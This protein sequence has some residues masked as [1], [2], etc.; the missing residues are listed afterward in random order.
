MPRG[1]ADQGIVNSMVLADYC[2]ISLS[3]EGKI[4]SPQAMSS[5]VPAAVTENWSQLSAEAEVAC[6]R[7]SQRSN[8]AERIR[9][10]SETSVTT[11]APESPPGTAGFDQ[12]IRSPEPTR[13]LCNAAN[14]SPRSSQRRLGSAP[15]LPQGAVWWARKL[16]QMT[17]EE[18]IPPMSR[19]IRCM[20]ACTGAS[21]ESF[22]L[23]ALWF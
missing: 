7:L 2:G 10:S 14:C 19:H 5:H 16:H 17:R 13:E 23:Q 8:S 15:K 4:H 20:S 12:G 1:L 22:V 3:L 6:L 21:A 11:S 18:D 9:C